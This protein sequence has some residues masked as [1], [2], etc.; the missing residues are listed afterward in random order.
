MQ[1]PMRQ[2][3]H[4]FVPSQVDTNAGYSGRWAQPV[5]MP[6]VLFSTYT[7]HAA[8]HMHEKAHEAQHTL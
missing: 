5:L 7:V 1:T 2:Q 8:Q 4:E 3:I 6:H